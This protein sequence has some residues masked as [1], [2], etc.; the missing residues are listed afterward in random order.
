MSDRPAHR[1]GATL[2]VR[3]RSALA[4][5]SEPQRV[6]A[7]TLDPTPGQP[8]AWLRCAVDPKDAIAV[9]P[10]RNA[11]VAGVG[12]YIVS[13]EE[14]ALSV[15]LPPG[16]ARSFGAAVLNAADEADGTEPMLYLPRAF[17]GA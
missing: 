5:F 16:L 14:H 4:A 17:E 13:G 7:G 12:F 2:A 9:R 1:R 11:G 10:G 15:V 8:I 6:R 3:L